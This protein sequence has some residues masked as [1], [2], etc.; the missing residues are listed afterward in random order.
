MYTQSFQGYTIRYGDNHIVLHGDSTAIHHE[1]RCIV[2]RFAASA[3]PYRV[4]AD[5]KRCMLLRA[6]H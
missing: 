2:R 3:L 1:A 4:V 6:A 5:L